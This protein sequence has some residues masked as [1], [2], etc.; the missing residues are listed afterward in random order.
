MWL[1]TTINNIFESQDSNKVTENTEDLK[2][3]LIKLANK[4]RRC[5]HNRPQNKCIKCTGYE[6][7]MS[8]YEKKDS[9][10]LHYY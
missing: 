5:K 7:H 8:D 6:N 1:I 10:V 2:K 4:E 9:N 3:K